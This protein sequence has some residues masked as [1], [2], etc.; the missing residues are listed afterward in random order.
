[1]G[2]ESR[3]DLP[4]ERAQS[5]RRRVHLAFAAIFVLLVMAFHW[6]DS[7]SMIAVILELAAYTY[8]PLLGL[9]AF[10]ILTRRAVNDRLVPLVAIGAPLLCFVLEAN[11]SRLL[12][13]YRLGFELLA[14]NGALVFVGLW[15][16]KRGQTPF[17]PLKGSEPF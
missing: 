8:G 17:G 13:G 15:L 6:A 16:I 12:G 1:L 4:E 5:I 3:R 14:V 7:A 2:L 11:Q 9:F 10:G